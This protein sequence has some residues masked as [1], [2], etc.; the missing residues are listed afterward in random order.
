MIL[1]YSIYI[2]VMLMMVQYANGEIGGTLA[3]KTGIAGS[4]PNFAQINLCFFQ[5]YISSKIIVNGSIMMNE[6]SIA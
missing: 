1:I 2:Y 5:V 6:W 4:I 3:W